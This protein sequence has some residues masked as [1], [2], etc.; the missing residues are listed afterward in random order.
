MQRMVKSLAG[1]AFASLACSAFA[2]PPLADDQVVASF[3]RML[4][5]APTPMAKIDLDALQRKSG[6]DPLL[7]AVNLA[8]WE[9]DPPQYHIAPQASV[10]QPP[11]R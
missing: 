7:R 4:R 1:L 3:E 9:Q 8:L 10:G 6:A 2:G 11:R 5:H